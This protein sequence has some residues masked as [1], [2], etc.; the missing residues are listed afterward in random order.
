VDPNQAIMNLSLTTASQ[1]AGEFVPALTGPDGF[2]AFHPA[3][4]PVDPPLDLGNRI[5]RALAPQPEAPAP[6]P[7]AGTEGGD[8]GENADDGGDGGTDD[9]GGGGE[10]ADDGGGGP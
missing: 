5:Q 10:N 9:G 8:E 6:A 2:A 7:G 4:L 1:R 3:L